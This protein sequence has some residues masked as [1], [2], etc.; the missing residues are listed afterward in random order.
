MKDHYRNLALSDAI[1]VLQEL[2]NLRINQLACPENVG[3][4]ARI[5]F[6]LGVA[7]AA[8]DQPDKARERFGSALFID[9]GMTIDR[10]YF[11]PPI[12]SLFEEVR[13]GLQARA[14]GGMSIA[15]DPNGADLFVDGRPAGAAPLTLNLP[16]GDHFV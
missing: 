4:A 15:T 11:P 10:V 2:E 1:R 5:S 7:H 14:T 12:V 3:F 13:V 9:P 8:T 16:E 6:W